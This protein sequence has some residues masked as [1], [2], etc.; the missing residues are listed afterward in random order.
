VH[1]TTKMQVVGQTIVGCP[2]NAH[3]ELELYPSGSGDTF[4][5]LLA[6]TGWTEF[7]KNGYKP[8]EEVTSMTIDDFYKIFLQPTDKCLE[9]PAKTW[10]I[11]ER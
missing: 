4:L 2:A 6:P 5:D 1:Y 10:P 7:I 3:V 11:P 8:L 9:T